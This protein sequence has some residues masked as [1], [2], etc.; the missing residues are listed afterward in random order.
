M[1]DVL[2]KPESER[3]CRQFLEYC[4]TYA[5]PEEVDNLRLVLHALSR[6]SDLFYLVNSVVTRLASKCRRLIEAHLLPNNSDEQKVAYAVLNSEQ[7][8]W[9]EFL[10]ADDRATKQP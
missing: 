4:F 3:L 6:N 2:P 7:R 9:L 1:S 5:T 8:A 10:L